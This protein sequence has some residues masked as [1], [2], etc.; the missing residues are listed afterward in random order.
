MIQLDLPATTPARERWALET[1]V[2]LARLLP[3][4]GTLSGAVRVTI[5]EG[6]R[7]LV[8]PGAVAVGRG[9][10]DRVVAIAGAGVEQRSS[11]RDQHDRVP[12]D[13]NPLVIERTDRRPVVQGMA[14]EFLAAV[15]KGAGNGP[16][17]R[18]APWPEGR[19]WAIAM[20][21][22]IDVVAGWPLFTL[23]RVTELLRKGRLGDVA[24]VVG[25]AAG[26]AFG[27][28]V[29]DALLAILAAEAR[30]GLPA[31]WFALVGD[32]TLDRW[33][34]GDVTYRIESPKSRRLLEAIAKAGHE[35]G[36]HGSMRTGSSP[37]RFA[38]E[39]ERLGQVTGTPPQGVRQH[40]LKMHPGDTQRGM[41]AAG[42]S[43]DATYGFSG[44]NG[45][46][47]GVADTV[48]GWDVDTAS[49]TTL[50][51]VPL[52]WMDRALSKYQGVEDPNALVDDGLALAEVARA[53]EGLWVG[54]WHPNLVPA[55]GYPGAPE[56]FDRMLGALMARAPWAARAGDIVAWR[57]AR[58]ATRVRNIAPDGRAELVG[59]GVLE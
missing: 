3:A 1:L 58:R 33:R 22:D 32:P 54:L 57:R 6:E 15:R 21:H 45:F 44:R 12:A 56:A 27:D 24:R 42:F 59:E 50:E 53:E 34:Q 26:S 46:R 25:A 28:P 37:D 5:G 40:F 43:Y 14:N 18:V 20:T 17:L 2:D 10:L 49:T 51:E 48:V 41:Q 39:R 30:H 13:A 55:L 31:T 16:V 36:L 19:R 4:E 29:T 47:L 35:I 52:H 38:E 9:A 11:A 7:Y 23:L 8:S